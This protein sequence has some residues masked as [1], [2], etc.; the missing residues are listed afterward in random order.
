[1]TVELSMPPLRL[2][3]S[4]GHGGDVQALLP[5]LARLLSTALDTAVTPTLA[6][7]YDELSDELLAGTTHVAWLPPLLLARA[8]LRGAR[9]AAVPLRGGW[10]TYR[11]ALLVRRDQPVVGLSRLR[12]LRAAWVDRNSGSGY[13]FPRLELAM[14][15]A[16]PE[17][18]FT[19]EEFFGSAGKAAAAV[20][21]GEADVCA[22]FVTDAAARAP[23]R[24]LEDVRR[25]LGAATDG[26]RVLHVTE[27]IPPD[28]FAMAA[29][30]SVPEQT[31]VTAALLALHET[32]GGRQV[33]QDLLQA[34]RL[35]PVNDAL[36]R[37]LRSWVDAAASREGT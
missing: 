32:A 1:M 25:T 7:S 36:L 4:R 21:A 11:S 16:M 2:G 17:R 24:A 30:L 12:G 10:L 22:C 14:L 19:S 27:P 23:D 5:G 29:R 28:G 13:L 35:S 33:L 34:D 8:T 3:A 20:V 18:V 6:Q 26:L 15:G 37:S 31:R 9:I